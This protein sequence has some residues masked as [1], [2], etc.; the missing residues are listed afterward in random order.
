MTG[1]TGLLSHGVAI[2]FLWPESGRLCSLARSR[3]PRP[4]APAGPS[5][6]SRLSGSLVSQNYEYFHLEGAGGSPPKNGSFGWAGPHGWDGEVGCSGLTSAGGIYR[7]MTRAAACRGA[8]PG[9]L[10]SF[11][12]S[13]ASPLSR[14]KAAHAS[15]S[16]CGCLV[17]STVRPANARC[18][19][20]RCE[21][22]SSV[23]CVTGGG[24]GLEQR[25]AQ[26]RKGQT[27]QTVPSLCLC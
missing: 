18:A 8:P 24:R 11:L 22:S 5:R 25:A 26:V 15:S 1:I 14:H 12:A 2:L 3:Q 17:C 21:D 19:S 9:F 27:E 6:S 10:A 23:P 20:L 16:R 7:G 13:V 4:S